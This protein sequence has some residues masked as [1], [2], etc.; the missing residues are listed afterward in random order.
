MTRATPWQ[1]NLPKA[2]A[3][4]QTI[5]HI[6]GHVSRQML[7]RY[8]HIRME[9]KRKALEVIVSK[10]AATEEQEPPPTQ[11]EKPTHHAAR[12]PGPRLA[13]C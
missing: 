13:G 4:D 12:A 2:E 3:G 11:E 6:A 9:D 5:M 1:R 10:P 8:S 7:A